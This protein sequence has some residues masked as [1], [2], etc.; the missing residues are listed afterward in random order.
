MHGKYELAKA[1]AE[2]NEAY[3]FLEEISELSPEE[4]VERVEERDPSF[5]EHIEGM[6]EPPKSTLDFWEGISIW[7]ISG[8]RNKY[9]HI[10]HEVVQAY[11]E[12]DLAK[13]TFAK[14][15]LRGEIEQI[16]KNTGFE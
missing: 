5:I 16:L 13:K 7:T 9:H 3:E 2:L 15:K 6:E 1:V 10:W 8:L 4:M 11:F 14:A 12:S